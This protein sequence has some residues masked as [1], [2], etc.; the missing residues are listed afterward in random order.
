[1]DGSILSTQI[2]TI[3]KGDYTNTKE[4][5]S[6]ESPRMTD[7]QDYEC[8]SEETQTNSSVSDKKAAKQQRIEI[9]ERENHFKRK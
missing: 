1:M 4:I 3:Q 7:V 9:W 2:V 5:Y 8:D 6:F